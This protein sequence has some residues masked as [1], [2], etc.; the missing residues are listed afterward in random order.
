MQ[1]RGR[2]CY[3]WM[4]LQ[5]METRGGAWTYC[6]LIPVTGGVT[7]GLF[8]GGCCKTKSLEGE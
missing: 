2:G 7:K 1:Y 5:V 3:D 6:R 8:K 4:W